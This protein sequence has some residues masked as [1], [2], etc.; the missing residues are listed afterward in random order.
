MY[1]FFS[2]IQIQQLHETQQE[3]WKEMTIVEYKSQEGNLNEAGA[4]Q[5]VY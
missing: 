4:G 2:S 3:L 1:A 5:V